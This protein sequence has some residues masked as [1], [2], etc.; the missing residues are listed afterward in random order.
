MKIRR[1][2]L[3]LCVC[4]LPVSFG[5]VQTP[6]TKPVVAPKTVSNKTATPESNQKDRAR[7]NQARSLL[8][9]LSTDARNFSDTTLRARS[10]ARIADTLW[11]VDVDQARLMF[12]KAWDAAET[13]DQEND[14]KVQEDIARQK[15]KSGGGYAYNEPPRIRREVLRLAARHDKILSEEFL[16]KLKVQ[17]QEGTNATNQR[18]GGLSEA[19]SQRMGLARELLGSG[20]VER[21]LEFADPALTTVGMETLDFLSDVREKA[22]AAADARFTSML[23]N[24]A[25]NPQ[26]DENTVSI[27]SSYIFTPHLFI[28]F[29][30]NGTSTSQRSDKVVPIEVA[31]ELRMA[32]FQAAAAIL[33]R[34][35]PTPTPDSPPTSFDARYLVIKR[36]L[37]FFEQSAPADMVESL[38]A[39]LNALNTIA[40]E[41]AR[42]RDDEWLNKGIKPD[43]SMADQEQALLDRVDRAKN[44]GERD[45]LHVQLAF[46]LMRKG[47]MRARDYVS[48][49]DD[50]ELR[51]GAQAYVDYMLASKFVNDKLPDQ[52]LE[53]VSKGELT[54]VQKVWVLT[55]CAKL[56]YKAD[57]EKALDL[58]DAAVNEARRLETSD[59]ALPQTLLAVANTLIL[60][61][62]G[63]AWD[64]TF[65]A[66]KAANSAE[67][68]TGEDGEMVSRFESKGSRSI[69]TNNVAEF[70]VEGI[71]G[72]L[73]EQDYERSV[74]LARGFQG[75]GPRAVA[76]IAIAKAVLE[77]KPAVKN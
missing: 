47:D 56:L 58:T 44:A 42:K 43:V 57:K 51:K 5:S 64:A 17:K 60:I 41:G 23:A 6:Q 73:A 54:H 74:E 61:E 67:K 35:L 66:V 3:T 33:L 32:F 27:L 16:E 52:A 2:S 25:N 8:V 7:R 26:S 53:L 36:V 13:A 76:T 48:K 68:F 20:D 70:N 9:A 10:L 29:S 62:P 77:K 59:P 40:S 75:E 31:P 24:A 49:I 69:T 72:K 18:M 63:R 46:L 55:Q 15:A 4:T 37:P 21:A 30:G 19:L 11:Q 71:F 39:Q 45:S 22:P 38:R 1:L 34:P 65:D 14:L 50:A 12:R 28:L